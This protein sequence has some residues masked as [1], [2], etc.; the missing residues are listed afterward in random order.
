VKWLAAVGVSRWDDEECQGWKRLGMVTK[1]LRR[2]KD[3]DNVDLNAVIR[4]VLTNG[5]HI[6]VETSLAPVDTR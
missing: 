5:D 2:K 4:D 6:Y 1:V 3:G